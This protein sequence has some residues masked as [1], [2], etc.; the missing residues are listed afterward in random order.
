MRPAKKYEKVKNVKPADRFERL[1]ALRGVAIVWMTI[2]HFCFD[3]NNFGYLNQNF[4]EDH[5]WTWQRSCIVSLF[6]F[7]AGSGQAVAFAN[8]LD[9]NRFFKRWRKVVAAAV[10]VTI[11]SYVVFPNS[12]IYFGILHGIAL[13]LLILRLTNRWSVFLIPF[14]AVVIVLVWIAPYAHHMIP[15]LG[16]MNSPWLNWI[17]FISQKPITEDYVPL[18][19][20]LGV[21]WIGYALGQWIVKY[22]THWFSGEL[23]SNFR[24][25]AVLGQWSLSYYLI[26]QPVLFGLV[27]VAK[28]ITG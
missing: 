8:G 2:F 5:F 7:C 4:Y 22:R 17:G 20:W 10:L 19:P 12:F 28:Q 27:Y 23:K 24:W 13:M 9:W 6:L 21:L 1:D 11:G 18:I 25:L 15:I 16:V 14:G 3:L 26:H